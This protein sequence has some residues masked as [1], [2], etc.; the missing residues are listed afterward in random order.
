MKWYERKDAFKSKSVAL[1]RDVTKKKKE[2]K[3][4]RRHFGKSF[5]KSD[6]WALLRYA[7]LEK[8][9]GR[10]E[11]CGASGQEDGIRLMVDH[12]KPISKFPEL[13]ADPDNLQVLCAQCN[14]GKM[15]RFQTRWRLP[16]GS[17]PPA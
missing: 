10:C 14:W 2:K 9:R 5:Y 15:A 13:R 11:C 17:A 1:K 6:E 12:I 8:S 3:Q 16:D 7:A 4:K